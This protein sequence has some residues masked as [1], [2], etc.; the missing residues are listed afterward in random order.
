MI[1]RQLGPFSEGFRT[2]ATTGAT[3]ASDRLMGKAMARS[4]PWVMLIWAGVIAAAL[5]GVLKP[6]AG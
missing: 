1:R 3:P 4:L 2:L 5:L 6:L